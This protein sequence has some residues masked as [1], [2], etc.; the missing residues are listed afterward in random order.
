MVS[1]SRRLP[2]W[3]LLAAAIP[4]VVT[5]MRRYLDQLAS[6]LRPGSVS[7]ADLALR[8]LAGFL[9]EQAPEVRFIADIRRRHIEDFRT[10]LTVRPGYRTGR[11]TPATLAH[12]LGTL[13]MFF[14][15]DQRLGLARST[16]P[17]P[18]HPRGP[19]PAGSSPA[20]SPRRP[21]RSEAPARRAG[22][23][24]HARARRGGSVAAHRVT[25]RG[26][27]RLAS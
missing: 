9:V 27:H 13:R 14:V 26:V 15:A 11:L 17:D 18:D 10:W 3:D 5:P 20:E 24:P 25:R 23:A 2:G 12:R 8:S 6:I 21:V 1:S 22:R 7:G 16:R 19:A 4:E